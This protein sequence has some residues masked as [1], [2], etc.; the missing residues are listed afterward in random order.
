MTM[1]LHKLN[2]ILIIFCSFL[3]SANCEIIWRRVSG[4]FLLDNVG[5]YSSLVHNN[6]IYLT[7]EF[8]LITSTDGIN[9]SQSDCVDVMI[10]MSVDS[11][12]LY[13]S[14]V[15][16]ILKTENN[17]V[18]CKKQDIIIL[19]TQWIRYIEAS[20]QFIVISAVGDGV[21]KG[22]MSI[23]FDQG[24]SWVKL[25]SSENWQ[26]DVMSLAILNNQLFA[27]HNNGIHVSKDSGNTW[28]SVLSDIDIHKIKTIG[29]TLYGLGGQLDSAQAIYK[30]LVFRSIDSGSTWEESHN[31]LAPQPTNQ[32]IIHNNNIYTSA[33]GKIF[34]TNMNVQNWGDLQWV[35]DVPLHTFRSNVTG[36]FVFNGILFA[37]TGST[38]LYS[39]NFDNATSVRKT[40]INRL[41]F[42]ENTRKYFV[43]GR[44]ILTSNNGLNR[45][46][47][48]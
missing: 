33:G 13:G 43:N 17:G 21:K 25:D 11:Q 42:F 7:G 2:V 19:A 48:K 16:S 31:D 32:L 26:T 20:D 6:I 18:T 36:L 10:N 41:I 27:G 44:V 47:Y 23:S 12:Y 39:T 1:I 22:G 29:D 45:I 46:L 9:W 24:T 14:S 35:D 15:G 3:V 30:S 5:V 38:G 8:G 4:G 37:A 34:R 28:V 40:K